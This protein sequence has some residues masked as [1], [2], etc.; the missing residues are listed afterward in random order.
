MTTTFGDLIIAVLGATRQNRSKTAISD[1]DDTR[2]IA[3][4]LDEEFQRICGLKPFEVDT[5]ATITLPASTR[6]VSGPAGVPL[7]RFYDWSWRINNAAGDIKLDQVTLEYIVNAHPDYET[8]EADQPEVVYLE[9]SSLGVY[10]L[11]KAGAASL[12]IQ[13]IYPAMYTAGTWSTTFPFADQGN[14]LLCAKKFAQY[15]YEKRK[16]LGSWEDTY[17]EYETAMGLLKVEYARAKRQGTKGY[18][19]FYNG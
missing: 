12:T 5:N 17:D 1:T 19:R 3:D 4:R 10:P 14:E 18:R 7:S 15:R 6:L 13:G 2:W 9:G 16:G 11:L 8:A